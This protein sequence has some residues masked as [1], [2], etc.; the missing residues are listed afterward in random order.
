M[1]GRRLEWVGKH[2]TTGS[3]TGPTRAVPACER[4]CFGAVAL[5]APEKE[6]DLE[7]FTKA[8]SSLGLETANGGWPGMNAA[9]EAAQ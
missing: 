8:I 5:L 7:A 1:S 9:Q 6:E 3:A 2:R 4:P